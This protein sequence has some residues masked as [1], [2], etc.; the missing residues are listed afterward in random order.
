M[1]DLVKTSCA[2]CSTETTNPQFVKIG[3]GIPLC[4][5]CYTLGKQLLTLMGKGRNVLAKNGIMIG[6]PN[7]KGR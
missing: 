4:E 7:N 6:I 5:T 2:W 1:N 3:A